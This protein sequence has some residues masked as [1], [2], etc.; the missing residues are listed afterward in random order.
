MQQL[1]I[2]QHAVPLDLLET[3]HIVILN[4]HVIFHVRRSI[5]PYES[6]KYSMT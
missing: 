1:I 4:A 6:P 5:L 3:L 2:V